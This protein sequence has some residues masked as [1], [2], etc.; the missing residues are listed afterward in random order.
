MKRIW[1]QNDGNG[2]GENVDSIVW[3][4]GYRKNETFF[5]ESCGINFEN[6]GSVVHP[7]YL[8]FININYPT[9]AILNMTSGNVP[10]PQMD[11]EVSNF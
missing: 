9:M 6:D 2:D 7:L 1:F 3:C 10:F 4:T 8:H 11:L 5:D